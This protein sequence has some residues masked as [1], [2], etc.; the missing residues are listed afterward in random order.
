[1]CRRHLTLV[2]TLWVSACIHLVQPEDCPG[3]PPVVA[4]QWR[5]DL[6]EAALVLDLNTACSWNLSLDGSSWYYWDVHGKWSWA[7]L[8]GRVDG[9]DGRQSAQDRLE[10]SLVYPGS[11]PYKTVGMSLPRQPGATMTAA[12]WGVWANDTTVYADFSGGVTVTL[13]RQ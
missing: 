10:I 2:A 9:R 13:V 11:L 5:G 12:A 6:A 4:G 8:T 7:S 1:M 3:A